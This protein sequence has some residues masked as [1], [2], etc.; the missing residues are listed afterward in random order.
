MLLR[1]KRSKATLLLLAVVACATLEAGACR[2]RDEQTPEEQPVQESLLAGEPD[3]YSA[4][5]IRTVEDTAGRQVFVTRV[6]RRGGMFREEWSEQGEARALIHRPDLGKSFQ[7][8]P[9][10]RTYMESE[11][12]AARAENEAEPGE[13]GVRGAGDDLS[14]DHIERAFGDAPA[15]ASVTT[16]ALAD[17]TIEGYS[18]AVTE[19]RAALEDGRAEV[20]RLFRARELAGLALRVEVESGTL[21]II[22]ERRD[23]Q[24]RVPL[25]IFDVPAD[26][27]KVA[28]RAPR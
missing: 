14:P 6:A 13:T 28:R 9:D 18:C 1:G 23:I 17:Q 24:T 21:K 5:V 12:T 27:R 3:E 19:E 7:L 16:L 25:E 2:N 11:A 15:P 10:N 26:F 8:F 20:T 22:T 4:T